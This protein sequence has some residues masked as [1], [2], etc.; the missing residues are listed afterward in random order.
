MGYKMAMP[1]AVLATLIALAAVP[2]HHARLA[3]SSLE[4]LKVKGTGF[5]ARERV[6]VRVT[7]STGDAITRRVRATGRGSFV[8]SFAGIQAC[9]GIE[10]VAT[11][12][13]GSHASFQSSSLIC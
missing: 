9:G 2:H 1:V 13:R 5:H 3:P 12:S 4:P 11:G 10:G 8:L 7:P 6:R